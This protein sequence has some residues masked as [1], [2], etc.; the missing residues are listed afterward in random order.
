MRENG[1]MGKAG[2]GVGREGKRGKRVEMTG[3]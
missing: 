3:K 1:G 2:K